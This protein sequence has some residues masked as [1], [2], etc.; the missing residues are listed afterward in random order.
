MANK[1]LQ[2][3]TLGGAMVLVSGGLLAQS[4]DKGEL[5]QPAVTQAPVTQAPVTQAPVAQPG[6]LAG[7]DSNAPAEKKLTAGSD[8]DP[9]PLVTTREHWQL[10]LNETFG[11]FTE[12]GTFASAGYAQITNSYP[13]Y[14]TNRIA[15]AQRVGASAADI[16]SHNFFGDFL[17]ASVLHEDPRYFRRGEQYGFWYRVGYG[18]SRAVVVRTEPG[19]GFNWDNVLGSALSTGLSNAYYPPASR[20]GR[21]M[22]VHFG[23]SVADYGA[24]NLF[25]EFWPDL[26]RKLF[27]KHHRATRNAPGVL[28]TSTS[29]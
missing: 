13:K 19:S 15:F 29:N 27:G 14:G 24:I 1:F 7:S 28:G 18:L 5:T 12:S 20:T 11:P 9:P 6:V 26:S 8:H 16:A 22:L 25:P 4:P 17:I 23:V 21:V 3:C 2:V 10:F